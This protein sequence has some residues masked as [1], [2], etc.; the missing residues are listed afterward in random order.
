[1][2]IIIVGCGNV[3]AT[4]AE[5]LDKEG[6]DVTVI[7]VKE[8]LVNNLSDACD[9]LGVVGNGASYSVQM[10]ADVNHA[11]ILIAVTGSDELNLL[12]CLIAKKAGGCHTI[13]R[14]S[15]PVYSR[16]IS[17]IREELGLSMIINPQQ[18]AAREMA[19]ILKFPSALKIDF[20]AKS[21]AELVTYRLEEGSPLCN[22]QLKNMGSR[23]KSSVLVA[24]VEREDQVIIPNGEFELK[25]KDI[26]SIVGT[27]VKT[28]EFFRKLGIPTASARDVIVVGGGRTTIYLAKQLLE[29]GVRVK[30]IERD[31]ERCDELS[32]MLPKATIING[33]GT[34]KE[35]LM[36]EGMTRTEAFLSMTDFDE[37][38]IMLALFAKSLSRAKLI[39]KVHRVA[40]DEIIDNLD[41]G[42]VVYP[43]FITAET[44]IKYIRAMYNSMGS[45]IETLYRLCDNR[46]EA[47]EF[48]IKADSPVVG[49]P[50]QD[51]KLKK[52]MLIGC[53]THRGQVSIPKGQ[54][55]IEVGDT[56]ILITTTTGLH[57]IRD[58]IR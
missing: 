5:Q 15:N 47:L 4:L 20:F 46:V 19:R 50:L 31:K 27:P 34:D 52:N 28:I 16:E 54:S 23:L 11:D 32:E 36:E 14:V 37:E 40:Y 21:R 22:M 49:I 44:I 18:A 55:V 53:I 42:S 6:H 56:V 33:D 10:E 25:A 48:Y 1:M 9:V 38:N 41:V 35:L 13:A 8:K 30:I 17:F 39:T 7:D 57:D 29:M 2:K 3:G 45:N 51:L 58:A 26:I 24:I 43:K 12:C